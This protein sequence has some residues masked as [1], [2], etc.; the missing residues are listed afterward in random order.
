MYGALVRNNSGQIL[1]SSDIEAL[2][3]AGQATFIGTIA[4]GLTNFP[5]YAA[6]DTGT[7]LS[8]R[9]IH[10][11]QFFSTTPPL[12]FIKPVATM[13]FHGILQ[14]WVSNNVWFVDVIQSGTIS[15]PPA[16]YAFTQARS[17]SPSSESHGFATYLP[18]GQV[19]FDSRLR[20]LAIYEARSVIP[21]EMPC[22]GGRPTESGP[23]DYAYRDT[24][25][26]HN[27][28]CEN[29]FNAYGIS[30]SVPYTNLMFSA[31]AVAQAVYTRIK[32]GFKR[33]SGFYSSQDHWSTAAW[34]AMYQSAYKVDWNFGFGPQI[35][36][37]WCVYAAGYAF[38]A[39]Y[40]DGSWLGIG[41]GTNENFGSRP[42]ADKTINLTPN[43]IIVADA[44]NYV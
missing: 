15:F 2:H 23:Y 22:D 40:E 26:D 27:F 20:P 24:T 5:D 9:H 29:T 17:L 39:Y 28:R 30:A 1:I 42:Y 44:S 25:L 16:V 6:D 43:T 10:R 34:W 11:Y 13:Y 3:Y 21:P 36:A 31:P 12:F 7:T 33:S 38:S 35:Q 37:G 41:G 14:Q 18:N 19:A 32:R 4:S 8:G